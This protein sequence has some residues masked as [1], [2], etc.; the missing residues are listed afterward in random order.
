MLLN[1]KRTGGQSR[2]GMLL[3]LAL[4]WL[5]AA[6]WA[7]VP[8]Q[9]VKMIPKIIGRVLDEDKHPLADVSIRLKGNNKIGATSN[10][11]GE[12]VITLDQTEGV[13]VFSHASFKPREVVIKPDMKLS[14]VVSLE[15]N[16][17]EKEEVVVTGYA[18]RKKNSYTG[19]S[20]SYSADDLKR[21]G[22]KNVLQSLQY[23]DPA[24]ALTENLSA[25]SNPNALPNLNLRGKSGLDDVKGEYAGNPNEPLFILDGFEASLQKIYD[26]DMNRIASVTLLKDASAKAIY[27]SKA[28]NGV[29]VIETI[30]PQEGEMRVSYNGNL[31]VEAPD[32][33]SYHL[34]NAREKLQVEVNAGRYT[35]TQPFTQQ[36]LREEYNDILKNVEEGV[37]TYWLS[38]PLRVGLGNKHTLYLEGGSSS[39]RYGIDLTYNNVA[40]VMKGSNRRNLGGSINLSYRKGKVNFRNILNITFNRANNSPYGSFSEYTKMNPYY[41]PT[42]ENENMKKLLGS[43]R[44]TASTTSSSATYY[45]NP[46]YNAQ[47]ETKNFS[48]YS[49]ITENFYV[50]YQALSSLKLTGR[51][52]YTHNANAS[53]VF[54]PGDHTSFALWTGDSY[55][56][57]GSYTMTDGTSSTL[58]ADL[59]ANWTKSYGKHVFFAN[60]GVNVAAF[61]S[62]THGMTAWGFLNNRVDYIAFAKQYADNGVPYGTESIKREVSL[63]SS[64]NY[65]YDNRY[66][67][68]V[69]MRRNASSVFGANSRWGN[70]WSVG[71]GWNMHNEAFFKKAS[72]VN[73][74]KLRGSIGSTGSQN[75][76]PY[77]AM[78]TYNFFTNSTYDNISGAYLYALANDNL[79]WQEAKEYNAGVD[80]KLFNRLNIRF[81]YY[82]KNTNNLLID[83]TLPTSTGFGSYKENLGTLRTIGYEGA[84]SYMVYSNPKKHSYVTLNTAFARN[85]NKIVHISDA[86]NTQNKEQDES[87][88]NISTPKTRYKEGQSMNAIWAVPSLGIDPVTGK[89]MF[90]TKEGK[91]TYVW[92]ADDQVVAGVTDPKLTGNFGV[93]LEYN[94]WGFSA[95]MRYSLSAGYYNSTLVNRVENVNIADNVDTRVLN[96]TW[97]NPGDQSYFKKITSTA[98]T[99]RPT[100]RFYQTKSDLTFSTLNL[101][102]D[103]KWHNIKRYGF[104]NLKLGF[105]TAEVFVASTVKTERGTD[106]PFSR[107]FSFSIQTNF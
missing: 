41:S 51:I 71:L 24:F 43:Y 103:F 15:K 53:E 101:Y 61:T 2:G 4:L 45:F 8:A 35:S 96:N 66:L 13:L 55:Y 79:K 98:T 21:V 92:N 42:D 37:N 78:A 75:F 11:Q 34:A 99:T 44:P 33:S 23:L 69:S 20:V 81:D 80:M 67:L 88:T 87:T 91:T 63:I 106:Y 74:L 10:S 82:L 12:F 32:L 14:L 65:A 19:A 72:Y 90:L 104:Q 105:Y 85:Y 94:G 57:R 31:N 47:L 84:I 100:T 25:G 70:F 27:G 62:D 30:R 93:S 60:G 83:F 7:Q 18:T 49:E 73:T 40:G 54:L 38:K 22:N 95:S 86:L 48:R 77:Q 1:K 29:V 89:E 39:M 102:Y 58:S 16:S 50:E 64:G 3:L 5:P 56:K 28:A 26:L 46:L 52:G 6:L 36:F 97:Q 59:Y 68:D 9:P 76:N 17:E 107:S